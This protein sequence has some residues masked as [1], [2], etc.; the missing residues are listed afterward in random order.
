LDVLL[1]LGLW[2][3]V[4]LGV[5]L[6]VHYAGGS[7]IEEDGVAFGDIRLLTKFR[8]VGLEKDSG[9]G[10]A[11]AVPVSFPSG[12]ADKYVGGGQVIANPKLI[13]EARGAGVQFAANGGV[14]IRPEEQQVEGNLEL[15]TEVTYGAMLGVHLGSEDVVAIGEAFGAAAITDIRADSRSNP[16]EALVGLRT[17]TLPGAVITVGGGVGII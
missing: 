14:R 4:E 5:D 12:D 13:L 11:I 9:A 8:L 17:L 1:V 3:R 7:G 16:L 15:G 6:P 2:E 10:V